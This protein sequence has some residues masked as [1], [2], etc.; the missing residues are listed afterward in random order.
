MLFVI[1]VG[2]LVCVYCLWCLQGN[3]LN[4]VMIKNVVKFSYLNPVP[5]VVYMLVIL[6]GNICTLHLQVGIY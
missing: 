3:M 6:T 5:I 2:D 4:K 1:N